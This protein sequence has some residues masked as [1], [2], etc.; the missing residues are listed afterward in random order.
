MGRKKAPMLTRL[1][2]T[3]HQR[4]LN[5]IV[6]LYFLVIACLIFALIYFVLPFV[7]NLLASN[8]F[9]SLPFSIEEY[10]TYL[11]IAGILLGIILAFAVCY[12][13]FGSS[14]LLIKKPTFITWLIVALYKSRINSFIFS[15]I[16]FWTLI[17]GLLGYFLLCRI[18]K[19]DDTTRKVIV[20][21]A[22]AVLGFLFGLIKATV[23]FGYAATLVTTNH[24]LNPPKTKAKN[25]SGSEEVLN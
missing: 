18:L 1:V 13:T 11:L 23:S 2:S 3:I 22:C 5:F 25:D 17:P 4:T 6:N 10:K 20:T 12:A 16:L 9:I 24:V 21:A 8:G 19:Y 14:L 7:L 15:C